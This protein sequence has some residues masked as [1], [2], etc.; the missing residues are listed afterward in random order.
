[1]LIRNKKTLPLLNSRVFVWG[2]Q[3]A[4]QRCAW[5]RHI[6]NHNTQTITRY[7]KQPSSCSPACLACCFYS[8][9]PTATAATPAVVIRT[10]ACG[11]SWAAWW[12][13]SSSLWC[14]R[15]AAG[16]SSTA[17]D[18]LTVAAAFTFT[19]NPNLSV[20]VLHTHSSGFLLYIDWVASLLRRHAYFKL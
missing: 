13:Q 3:S 15:R 18:T 6:S 1:M 10:C 8:C 11:S 2:D 7:H 20:V 14:C 17:D 16:T 4:N 9:C 19:L 5:W 12:Q